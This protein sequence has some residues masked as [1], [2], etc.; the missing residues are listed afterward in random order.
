MVAMCAQEIKLYP[1]TKEEI[2]VGPPLLTKYERAKIIGLRALQLDYG[3]FPMVDV[4][5][6]G[7][8]KD[9]LDIARYELD[10]GLL[11]LSIVRHMPAGRTQV[12]PIRLLVG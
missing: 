12:I 5:A 6:L 10:H 9:P 4:E 2:K 7:I 3:A 1:V 8:K 11:P